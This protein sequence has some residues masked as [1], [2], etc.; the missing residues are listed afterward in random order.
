MTETTSVDIRKALSS[1]LEDIRDEVQR[2]INAFNKQI[3][4]IDH[5]LDRL[6]LRDFDQI[7]F[8][9][10]IYDP[11]DASNHSGDQ[12]GTG[13]ATTRGLKNAVEKAEREYKNRRGS[14]PRTDSVLS[15]WVYANL[16]GIDVVIPNE[17]WM[18]FS[19][20]SEGTIQ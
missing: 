15:Y 6:G 8:T 14:S 7:M 5:E 18:Q 12:P 2:R 16:D 1:A 19:V 9:I 4:I 3:E 10:K 13:E 20:Q 17:V 11:W